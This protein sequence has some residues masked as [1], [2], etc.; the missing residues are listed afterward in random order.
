MPDVASLAKE[1]KGSEK[2]Y[3]PGRKNPMILSK[4]SPVL[5]LLQRVRDEAHRFA[6]SYHKRLRKKATLKSVLDDI[7]GVGKKRRRLL[8]RHF[9]SIEGVKNASVQQLAEA[10]QNNRKVAE[11]VYNYFRI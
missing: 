6:I 10:L 3:R 1:E 8:L 11:Q 5:H 9:G 4:N 2:I 7:S